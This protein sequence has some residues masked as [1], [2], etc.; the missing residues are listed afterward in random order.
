[1]QLI[2]RFVFDNNIYYTESLQ[3]GE[4]HIDKLIEEKCLYVRKFDANFI[5][6]ADDP[7]P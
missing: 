7:L 1:M 6:V 5:H 2:H 4:P 3:L